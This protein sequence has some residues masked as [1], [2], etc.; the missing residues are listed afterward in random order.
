[1]EE[2]FID[3]LNELDAKEMIVKC[4]SDPGDKYNSQLV[5]VGLQ[6]NSQSRQGAVCIVNLETDSFLVPPTPLQLYP[7]D[8]RVLVHDKNRSNITAYTVLLQ[9]RSGEI[10]QLRGEIESGK[11]QQQRVIVK[12]QIRL[13]GEE[14]VDSS[15]STPLPPNFLCSLNNKFD[16][17]SVNFVHCDQ[18]SH[19]K[20]VSGSSSGDLATTTVFSVNFESNV[21]VLEECELGPCTVAVVADSDVVTLLG[22]KG[23]V[24]FRIGYDGSVVDTVAEAAKSVRRRRSYIRAESPSVFGAKFPTATA[25]STC[26]LNRHI[27]IGYANGVVQL[28]ELATRRVFKRIVAHSAPVLRVFSF[29][30]HSRLVSSST[31][32]SVRLDVIHTRALRDIRNSASATP[33]SEALEMQRSRSVTP[34]PLV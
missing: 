32:G 5:A 13:V 6:R 31:N 34:M 8:V 1:V 30:N 12:E 28:W 15:S 16:P 27:A 14:G 9:T 2:A 22:Q 20:S 23:D 29:P 25:V 11:F 4:M 24:L 7:V 26:E 10:L 33:T 18:G 19:V 17:P 21:T 3:T